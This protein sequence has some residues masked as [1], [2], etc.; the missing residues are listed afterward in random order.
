MQKKKQDP[1]LEKLDAILAELERIQ[2]STRC[3]GIHV[4][5]EEALPKPMPDFP[6]LP[7][8]PTLPWTK[9]FPPY[10]PHQ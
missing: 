10:F 2:T 6:A 1:I 3:P 8:L 5:L 7:Q 4:K 9:M